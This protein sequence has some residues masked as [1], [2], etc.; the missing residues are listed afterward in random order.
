MPYILALDQGTTSSRAIIFDHDAA[1]VAVGQREFPQIFPQPG[2]VE[3]D[4]NEI[5]A[6]QI[7]VVTEALGRA[8]LRPRDIAAIGITNQRETT[9]LW[10]RGTGTPV[11]L[12]QTTVVSRWL[13]MP[14][15]ARS[16]AC[17]PPVR[18]AP[19]ITVCVLRQISTGSCS[20]HPGWG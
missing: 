3:H 19:A 4:P 8:H 15:A 12:S 17:R 5:W 7:A 2:W 20:T 6:T 16:R 18:N 11:R 1:I 14:I 10:E 9:V 13:V